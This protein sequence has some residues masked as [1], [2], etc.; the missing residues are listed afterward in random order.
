MKKC[1]DGLVLGLRSAIKV[2]EEVGSDR[3]AVV[4]EQQ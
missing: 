4:G 1:S 3:S 2:G